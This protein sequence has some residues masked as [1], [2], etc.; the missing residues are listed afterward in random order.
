MKAKKI[1]FRPI[2]HENIFNIWL[3]G[4]A[5]YFIYHLII[6]IGFKLRIK[7]SLLIPNGEIEEKFNKIKDKL[8]INSKVIIRESNIIDS[9]LLVGIFNPLLLIP[10][11]TNHEGIDYIITHELVHFKRGDLIYKLFIFI[12]IAYTLVQSNHAFNGGYLLQG[13]RIIM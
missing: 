2:I 8:Q 13:F 12:G 1:Q 3:L 4:L 6:C 11:N 5:I 9:P 7:Q 10:E